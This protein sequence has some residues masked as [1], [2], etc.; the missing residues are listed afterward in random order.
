MKYYLLFSGILL[1]HESFAIVYCTFL[2]SS[3]VN[4]FIYIL[5]SCRLRVLHRASHISIGDG[6]KKN[7]HYNF[8]ITIIILNERRVKTKE[9]ERKNKTRKNHN[10]SRETIQ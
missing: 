7:A 5:Q 9:K 10:N 4:V 6:W 8:I 2:P 1:L 3:F